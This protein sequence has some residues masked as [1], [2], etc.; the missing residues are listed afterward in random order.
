MINALKIA[1]LDF[2]YTDSSVLC[3]REQLQRSIPAKKNTSNTKQ[4]LVDVSV[5]ILDDARTGIQRVVRALLKQLLDNPPAGY[6]IRP[7]F[8]SVE[9]DYHYA[10]ESFSLWQEKKPSVAVTSKSSITV[11]VGDVFLGLD[12]AAHVLPKHQAQLENWK[13]KGVKIHI[14][15]YD[16]LPVLHPEW[17]HSKTTRNF[18][19]WLRTVAIVAD[20]AICISKTVSADLSLWLVAKYAFATDTLPI[21]VIP[22]GCDIEAS[23]PSKGLPKNAE[24]LLSQFNKRPTALMVGTLEP[25][26]GHAQV[27]DA[28]EHY[29]QGCGDANLLI[30]G[31]PGWK[32]EKLQSRLISHPEFEKRMFWLSDVSDEFLEKIYIASYGLILASESEGFG[33]PLIEAMRYGKPV[34]ARDLPVYR[35]LEMRL[36]YMPRNQNNIIQLST[37]LSDWIKHAEVSDSDINAVHLQTWEI[38]AQF[39]LSYLVGQQDKHILHESSREVAK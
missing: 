30:V 22:M 3:A 29:W 24:G 4:L 35:E 17:F 16:L 23:L 27:L 34:F 11:A 39:L 33:L 14:L 10:P 5:I 19:R 37:I 32:T 25:R 26:K 28:F 38:S 9:H 21:N 8:S 6:A 31:K 15:V 12:L 18:Y 36:S 1:A 13:C 7:V 2:L 20:S